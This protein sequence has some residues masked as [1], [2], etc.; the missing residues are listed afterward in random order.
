MA[1]K[2][3]TYDATRLGQQ[4]RHIVPSMLYSQVGTIVEYAGTV[5]KKCYWLVEFQNPK[6]HKVYRTAF[7]NEFLIPV[8]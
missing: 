4:V 6:T 3:T 2:V 1:R 5:H 8:S 7:G